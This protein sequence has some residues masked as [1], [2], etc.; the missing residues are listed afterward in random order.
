MWA[1]ERLL[2]LKPNEIDYQVRLASSRYNMGFLLF[3]RGKFEQALGLY[4]Q[5]MPVGIKAAAMDPDD[6]RAQYT[7]AL[8]QTRYAH[9]LLK[10][11]RIEKAR[12][13]F[14]ECDRILEGIFKRDSSLR[15]QYA[16]GVNAVRLGELYAYL[17]GN[18]HAGRG[19]QLD[20]WRQARNC[21]QR[22]VASLRNVTA[23]A[24]LTS[25]DMVDVRDGEAL[26][27]R[28]DATLAQLGN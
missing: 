25:G 10:T 21:L 14:L 23:H 18:S 26:L 1:D 7:L 8:Y 12:K 6:V 27:A 19:A 17:A 22:G 4:E 20:L 11:G 9:A 16:L 2:A 24:T 15:T 3:T 5:A 13:L 28:V